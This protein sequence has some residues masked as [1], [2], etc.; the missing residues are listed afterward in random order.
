MDNE[1]LLD[2]TALYLSERE[3][4]VLKKALDIAI[5]QKEIVWPMPDYEDTVTLRKRLN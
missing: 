2:Q 1:Y 4:E 5:A 3:L